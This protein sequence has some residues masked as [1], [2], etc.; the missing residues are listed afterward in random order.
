MNKKYQTS[1]VSPLRVE[2]MPSVS[3]TELKNSTAD[4]FDLVATR[5]AVAIRRHDKPRAVLLSMDAYEALTGQEP[6]WLDGLR[7]QY[8]GMLEK[9]QSPEQKEAA[10]RLFEATPQ[11]LGEAALRGT[12]AKIASG[13]IK[14]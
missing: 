14:P 4:V 11:E 6:D 8:R 3:A 5:Q 7:Q 13:E 1:S 2:E 12:Q 10:L 9:M